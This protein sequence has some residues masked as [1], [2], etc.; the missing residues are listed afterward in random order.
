MPGLLGR[1]REELLA[2]EHDIRLEHTATVTAWR[3]VA[4]SDAVADA[5]IRSPQDSQTTRSAVPWSS[6]TVSEPPA[7]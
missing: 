5:G 3:T 6:T 2:E 7:R 1:R 4:C